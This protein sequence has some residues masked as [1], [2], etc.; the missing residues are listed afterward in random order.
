MILYIIKIK[1]EKLLFFYSHFILSFA[2]YIDYRYCCRSYSYY[3]STTKCQMKSIVY[4]LIF[5]L[6][7]SDN[8]SVCIEAM[9][10][11]IARAK[12]ESIW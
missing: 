8:V 6:P 9:A 1:I 7:P 11:V 2:F 12:A 4:C 5:V 10:I 3:C